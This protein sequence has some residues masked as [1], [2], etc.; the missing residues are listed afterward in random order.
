VL[1][2]VIN[3]PELDIALRIATIKKTA[4]IPLDVT[5]HSQLI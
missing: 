4:N 1:T 5:F 3:F 2:R